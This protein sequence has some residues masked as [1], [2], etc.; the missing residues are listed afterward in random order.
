MPCEL[1]FICWQICW[2]HVL[3]RAWWW[4]IVILLLFVG[5]LNIVW[6]GWKSLCDHV[7]LFVLGHFW[8]VELFLN[9][10][11]CA[12]GQSWSYGGKHADDWRLTACGTHLIFSICAQWNELGKRGCFLSV[13][14]LNLHDN[15]SNTFLCW[16]F[17]TVE[18]QWLM[19]TQDPW[20]RESEIWNFKL[21]NKN[22]DFMQVKKETLRVSP[23]GAGLGDLPAGGLKVQMMLDLYFN[24]P[25]KTR[26][27]SLDYLY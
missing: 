4:D 1:I 23:I 9:L 13:L 20:R 12:L 21:N 7:V 26:K 10:W 3:L 25:T 14:C 17:R 16:F 19:P 8:I 24:F 22:L 11:I 5:I 6:L 2:F 18:W 27:Y 15:E